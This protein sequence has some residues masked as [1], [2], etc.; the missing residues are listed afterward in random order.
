MTLPAN[1]VDRLSHIRPM[2]GMSIRDIIGAN[3][4]IEAE[5]NKYSLSQRKGSLGV[6]LEWVITGTRGDNKS[7]PDFGAGCPDI[8]TVS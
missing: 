5:G 3:V 7:L 2:I 1:V 6:V 4:D 8:K